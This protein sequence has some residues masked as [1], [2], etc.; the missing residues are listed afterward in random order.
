MRKTALFYILFLAIALS[1]PS[2]NWVKQEKIDVK[3]L[4]KEIRVER[5]DRA[6]FNYSGFNFDSLNLALDSIYPGFYREFIEEILGLGR[7]NNPMLDVNL[8]RFLQNENWR[9]IQRDIETEF[10]DFESFKKD[11]KRAFAYHKHYFPAL[12]TPDIMLY[13]SAFNY[14]NHLTEGYLGIGLEFYLGP[15][16]EIIALLANEEFPNYVKQK[17]RAEFLVPNTLEFYLLFNHYVEPENED[18][19]SQIIAFGKIKYL[20]SKILPKAGD[21]KIML[22]SKEELTWVER[23]EGNIWKKFVADELLFSTE[24]KQVMRLL[25][26]GPFTPGLPKESPGRVAIWLGYKMVKDYMAKNPTVTIEEL[27]AEQNSRKIL[28]AYKPK[29]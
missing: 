22:Y 27:L 2:C 25:A 1:I 15:E 3:H 20:L 10:S 9:Q 29:K 6:L 21:D 23:N 13:N 7:F 8:L 12:E 14:A 28:S 19:L 5:L 18:F 4:E 24:P 26:D 16:N 17:M 11:F